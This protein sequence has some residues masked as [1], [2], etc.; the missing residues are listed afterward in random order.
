MACHLRE[1][2]QRYGFSVEEI[3]EMA[4]TTARV[5]VNAEERGERPGPELEKKI[6]QA[7]GFRVDLIFQDDKPQTERMVLPLHIG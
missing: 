4:G 3:A 7:I 1:F 2:R 5:I 6:A